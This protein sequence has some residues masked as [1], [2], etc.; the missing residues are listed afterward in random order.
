MIEV[1]YNVV[2]CQVVWLRRTLTD[3]GHLLARRTI[4]LCDNKSAIILSKKPIIRGRTKL[5]EIKYHYFHSLIDDRVISI[6]H[7]RIEDQV[8]NILT[9]ALATYKHNSLSRKCLE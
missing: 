7:C 1:E 3:C 6:Q 2:A 8:A 4:K 9:K 5:I